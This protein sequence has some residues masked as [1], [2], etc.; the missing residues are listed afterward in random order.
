MIDR[1]AVAISIICWVVAMI[2]ITA[3]VLRDPEHRS[4]DPLYRSAFDAWRDGRSAYVGYGGVNYL[5]T[6]MAVY[7]PFEALPRPWGQVLWRW[8]AAAGFAHALWL[9]LG[10]MERP[11][12][13]RGFLLLT[14]TTLPITLGAIQIGQANA[15]LA[16]ALLYA[17]SGLARSR[18]RL[19]ATW[20]AVGL[21]VKPLM[22]AAMGL[23]VVARPKLGIP[24][25][26]TTAIAVAVPFLLAPP[27][28]V[29]S[30]HRASISNLFGSCLWVEEHRFADLNGIFRAVGHP[31]SPSASGVVRLVAGLAFAALTAMVAV[32]ARRAGDPERSWLWFLFASSAYL[33]LFNP[34]TESNSYCMMGIPMALWGWRWLG[35]GEGI[36]P[37]APGRFA[38]RSAIILGWTTMAS[39]AFAGVASELA[40]PWLG[41]SLDLWLLPSITI[42]FLVPVSVESLG[43]APAP[44]PEGASAHA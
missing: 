1:Y 22:V 30:E 32:R 41:N 42:A 14:L 4:L 10:A 3:G 24:L 44:G 37:A 16:V 19:A 33:M 39:V 5:P 7:G 12:L 18:D 11:R 28:F 6:F 43:A 15:W 35:T 21:A 27:T 26:L 38:G 31:I 34:M 8:L 36:V 40:R 20:L 23:A 25:V 29:A 9:L 13:G 2:V 17:T